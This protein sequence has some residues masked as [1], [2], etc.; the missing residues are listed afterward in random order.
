M[1]NQL[2]QYNGGGFDLTRLIIT[3]AVM[4][5]ANPIDLPGPLDDM[6]VIFLAMFAIGLIGMFKGGER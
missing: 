3:L 6:G 4:Y 2:Q 5:I 1:S